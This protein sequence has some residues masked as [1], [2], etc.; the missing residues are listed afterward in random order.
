MQA[1]K[2]ASKQVKASKSADNL[3]GE[4]VLGML[5]CLLIMSYTNKLAVAAVVA[6]CVC[7]LEIYIAF[8]CSSLM[9][10]DHKMIPN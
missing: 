1:S 9:K 5:A 8:Y 10:S 3:V 2:Q 4:T 6:A 7:V